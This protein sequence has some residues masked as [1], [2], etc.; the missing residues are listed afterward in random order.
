[1]SAFTGGI[2]F[3]TKTKVGAAALA[4]AAAC[5]AASPAHA[6]EKVPAAFLQCDGRVG[7][8]SDGARFARLLLVTATAG[9]SEAAMSRDNA[10]KRAK[11]AA[12]VAAC[13]QAIASEGAA[14]R[15]GQLG[16]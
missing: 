10:D 13:D 4:M 6:D 2:L 14:S 16:R 5:A 8:V 7:H 9:I 3:M 15:Q 11:G 12:G 1:M